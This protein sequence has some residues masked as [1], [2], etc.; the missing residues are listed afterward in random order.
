MIPERPRHVLLSSILGL[1]LLA[2]APLQAGSNLWTPIGPDG[3][4][5]LLSVNVRD[6]RLDPFDP[7]TLYAGTEGGSV[8]VYTR[9]A[10][11]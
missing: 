3:V 9:R 6:L 4:Q 7:D 5:G 1:A 11:E 2:A 10:V 8:Y